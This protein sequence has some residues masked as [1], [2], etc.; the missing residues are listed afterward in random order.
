[1]RLA[2]PSSRTG[3]LPRVSTEYATP[4]TVGRTRARAIEE[5]PGRRTQLAVATLFAGL[6][7]ALAATA[8]A[9]GSGLG[10]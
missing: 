9:I 7:A 5:P 2:G 8:A 1:M 10:G 3:I 4:R 6:L